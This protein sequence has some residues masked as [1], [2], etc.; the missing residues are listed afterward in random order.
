MSSF[1]EYC[2]TIEDFIAKEVKDKRQFGFRLHDHNDDGK[3][4][5]V[6]VGWN[7]QVLVTANGYLH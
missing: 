1:D 4:C 3:I 2:S 6:D 5:P 7:T